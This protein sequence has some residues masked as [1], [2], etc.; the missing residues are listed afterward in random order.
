MEGSV[1]SGKTKLAKALA[2][3]LGML[4]LP[5]A[6]LDMMYTNDYGYNL[7]LLDEQLPEYCRSFDINNFLLNPK[8]RLTASF[9]IKQYCIK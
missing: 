6:N 9:Q 7:K 5:E 4:Y 8:H 2:E 1:A 3:D